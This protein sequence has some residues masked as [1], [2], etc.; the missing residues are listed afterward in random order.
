MTKWILVLAVSLVSSAVYAGTPG[1]TDSCGL[2]W[3]VTQKKSFLAT[4]TRGTTNA[5]VPPTFGMTTGSIGC[6]QHTFAKADLGAARFVASN[7]DAVLFDM[8]QGQGESLNALAS[9][10]GCS[11]TAAFGDMTKK[12]FSS[13]VD[14][15]D[16]SELV[17]RLRDEAS[18]NSALGCSA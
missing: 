7:F 4:S 3:E 18:R 1:G 8:A 17:R 13:L 10:M 12:E 16:A 6:D 11:N 2:G 14:G 15:A 5:F 9:S